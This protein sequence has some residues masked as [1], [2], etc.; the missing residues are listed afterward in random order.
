MTLEQIL[1]DI[2]SPRVKKCIL[3]SD[4]YNE[5]DDQYA[6]AH[7]LGCDKIDLLS[8]NATPFYN[9]R[10]VDFETGMVDSYNEILRLYDI[11]GVD[12][13]KIPAYE[14]SRRRFSADDNFAPIDSPAARNIIKTVKESDEI[15]YVL[16]TGSCI[17]VVSACLIDPSI[18]SNM[19]VLWIGGHELDYKDCWEFNLSQDYA[20]GQLLLNC[21]VPLV[22]IPVGGWPESLGGTKRLFITLDDIH[23]SIKG[24]G[25]VQKFYREEFPDSYIYN[26]EKPDVAAWN[27]EHSRILY[28]VAAPAVISVPE[29]FTFKIVP[30]PSF[31]DNHFY[32]FDKTRHKMIYVHTIDPK[33]VLADTFKS[34]ENI[35]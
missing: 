20:A 33:V 30:T 12:A 5:M 11:C 15:I 8:V 7:C 28:D 35:K 6:F 9:G 1:D 25:K 10:S 22:M 2:K 32:G 23:N 24:D 18:K 4:M 19:C 14:G 34:I 31:G 21:A 26:P 27:E 17:N 3:A 16:V 13:N 29:A